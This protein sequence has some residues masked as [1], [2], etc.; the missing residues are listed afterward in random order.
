MSTRVTIILFAAIAAA[1]IT[2]TAD[3][4][5]RSPQDQALY[6]K[7]V[8]DC[9]SPKWPNGAWPVINYSGGWY[10]CQESRSSR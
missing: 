9:N 1:W 8:K 2:S 3:A 6:E 5:Q 4:K 7:A 10:R